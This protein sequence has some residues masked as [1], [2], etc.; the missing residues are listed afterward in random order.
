MWVGQL[1]K[2]FF[3]YYVHGVCAPCGI[4]LFK[5]NMCKL[6]IVLGW[7][8]KIL[9]SDLP[10]STVKVLLAHCV[11]FDRFK[12]CAIAKQAR[13]KCKKRYQVALTSGRNDIS[14]KGWILILRS[15]YSCCILAKLSSTK[16]YRAIEC[17][18]LSPS[19]IW[20]HALPQIKPFWRCAVRITGIVTWEWKW[21]NSVWTKTFWLSYGKENMHQELTEGNG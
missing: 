15:T 7:I 1:V 10:C 5:S 3:L 19:Q 6:Y 2:T 4:L 21:R 9:S 16:L 18:I 11:S 12:T 8:F 17:S 20:G 14:S 13:Q